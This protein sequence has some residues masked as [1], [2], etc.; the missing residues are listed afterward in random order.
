MIPGKSILESVYD[1][2]HQREEYVF[3]GLGAQADADNEVYYDVCWPIEDGIQY[4]NFIKGHIRTYA[5]QPAP[6]RIEI[7][8]QSQLFELL[9]KTTK[10]I[11]IFIL[12]TMYVLISGTHC[13]R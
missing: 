11:F 8:W 5:F 13:G 10:P 7:E 1:L 4:C 12:F 9:P 2:Q 6:I 3:K